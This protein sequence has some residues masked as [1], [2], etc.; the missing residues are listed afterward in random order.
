MIKEEEILK[1]K[2]LTDKRINI[3]SGVGIGYLAFAIVIS[4]FVPSASLITQVLVPLTVA[5]AV[6]VILSIISVKLNYQTAI[7]LIEIQSSID[8][9][10]K[11]F[12]KS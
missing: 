9:M 2:K 7:R 11:E 1:E 10:K 8:D 5:V 6:G 12:K 4:L 3:L